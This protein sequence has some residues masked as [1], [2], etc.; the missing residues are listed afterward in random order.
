MKRDQ[1][2][3]SVDAYIKQCSP[4][5]RKMLIGLRATIRAAA[6]QASEK[7]SYGMPTFYQRG[8]LVHF[9]AYAGHIGFYPAPS[10]IKAFAKD[11]RP[12]RS[13]KGAVQFPLDAPLP[14]KLIAKIVKF[15][16]AEN[17]AHA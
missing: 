14:L 7:I 16:V 11:L 10:A 9:A 17:T 5:T 4:A 15:R 3:A 13:S 12:Y 6:P 1:A 2:S 8:N